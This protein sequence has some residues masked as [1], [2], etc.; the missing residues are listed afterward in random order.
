MADA[1][2]QNLRAPLRRL[3]GVQVVGTGSYVPDVVVRNEDLAKY[4]CDPQWIFERSGIRERRHT[5]PHQCTSDLAVE[6]AR[7]AVKRAGVS[8]ADI[9][10]V[11]VGTF[12]PD[13]LVPSTACQVQHKLGLRCAAFD[14]AAGCAGF[15][16]AL[17]TGAQFVAAG[18]S[19]LALVIGADTT[20]R[21]VEPSDKKTYPLFGDGA[22]A[23]LLS[24]GSDEQGLIA[25]TMGADGSGED[26]LCTK[27]GSR[28]PATAEAIA[29]GEHYMRMEGRS[30]FKW[31]VRVIDRSSQDV[32]D[33]AKIST[34][35]IDLA[36]LHQANI[37]ILDA[38]AE[39][40]DLDR[41]KMFVN[42]EKYGNTSGGS[43]PLALDEAVQQDRVK[44]GDTLLLCGF[45]AG[46]AWGTAL[47]RW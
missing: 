33:F 41:K 46:L 11:V 10:L 19:R 29:R 9:D 26:L 31:A 32:L 23:V 30:V 27:A 17:V 47:W 13:L 14:L 44:R 28:N 3:T 34:D 1:P 15:M 8:A 36:V 21:I 5:P 45:G 39:T 25:Y 35:Q 24:R 6:A 7:R 2:E 22:G 18:T 42:L 38:A 4:G 43:I 12:T 16:Y 20:S 37:R 40:L